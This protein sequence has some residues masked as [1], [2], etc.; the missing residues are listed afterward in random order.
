MNGRFV[1]VAGAGPRGQAFAA[2]MES[3]RE[4]GL[5]VIG[6]LDDDPAFAEGARWPWLGRLA[7]LENVLR[8][9]VVDEVA[10]CL[11]FSQWQYIDGIA[12]IAEEAGKIVRVPMDVLDHSF[13]RARWR[14]STARR[15]TRSSPGRTGPLALAA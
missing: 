9:H 5:R 2:T 7:D 13:A 1:L 4:L 8:E 11:P 3:H 12:H 6:F 14:T 10:I 15:S